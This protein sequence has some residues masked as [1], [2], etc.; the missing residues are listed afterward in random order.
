LLAS[1]WLES[2]YSFF[3]RGNVQFRESS[4]RLNRKGVSPSLRME[5]MKILLDA[6]DIINVVEHAQPL[7][8]AEFHDWLSKRN[9]VLVYSFENIRALAGPLAVDP[10]QVERIVGYLKELEGLPHCYISTAIDLLE[11]RA[12]VRAFEEKREYQS[13]D[14]YVSRFDCVFPPVAKP[15]K[16]SYPLS[17]VIL[18]IFQRCPQIFARRPR[19]E[20]VYAFAMN[21][22]RS[23]VNLKTP[24]DVGLAFTPFIETL[25]QK[26]SVSRERAEEIASW[27]A[28]EPSRCPAL[29]LV[30]AVGAVISRDVRYAPRRGDVFD[31]SD[32]MQ[33]PYVD[34]A[35]L[36]RAM[37]HYFMAGVRQLEPKGKLGYASEGI[38]RSLSDLLEASA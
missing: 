5:G 18:D 13:I 24:V 29:R 19:L 11:L 26:L 8:I 38:F 17:E 31:L 1:L 6:K 22:D 15:L 23:R 20:E 12:A 35:T 4:A 9:A 10:S 28:A 21:E 36:D 27:V 14:P 25:E 2:P 37:L 32:I 16:P 33:I 30:R 34:K 7:S 3:P